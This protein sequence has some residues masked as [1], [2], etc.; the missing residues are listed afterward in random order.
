MRH[1]FRRIK[2]WFYYHKHIE[3]YKSSSL[4]EWIKNGC[5]THWCKQ[6]ETNWEKENLSPLLQYNFVDGN[7]KIDYIG[8]IE[9]F[10]YDCKNIISELNKLFEKNNCQK[11]ISYKNIK[12]NTSKK[13]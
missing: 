1:P 9:N 4:N 12:I 3:P 6:N 11:R 5:Q 8:K 10:E 2:S 13:K 7:S